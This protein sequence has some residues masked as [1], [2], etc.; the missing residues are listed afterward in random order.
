MTNKIIIIII[1]IIATDSDLWRMEEELRGTI[2]QQVCYVFFLAS[3]ICKEYVAMSHDT[4]M[5]NMIFSS[6]LMAC[7][8]N[9]SIGRR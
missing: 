5:A 1:I 6:L 8:K 9:F 7:R 2:R 4:I 3:V